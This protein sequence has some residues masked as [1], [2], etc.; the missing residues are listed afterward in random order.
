MAR[1]QWINQRIDELDQERD[2]HSLGG[3]ITMMAIGGG[4]ILVGAYLALFGLLMDDSCHSEFDNDCGT[5]GDTLLTLGLL[6]GLGGG[7]LLTGGAIWL[8]KKLKPRRELGAQI[9]LLEREREGIEMRLSIRPQ[10]SRNSTGL[11]LLLTF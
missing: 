6:A 4:S 11:R 10:L 8:P 9:K 7:A 3:P 1:F 2:K 5:D